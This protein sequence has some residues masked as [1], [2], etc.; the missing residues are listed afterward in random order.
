MIEHP[1]LP[2]RFFLLAKKEK[3]KMCSIFKWRKS[4]Q[5]KNLKFKILKKK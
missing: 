5:K 3:L 4:R 2:Q 1:T